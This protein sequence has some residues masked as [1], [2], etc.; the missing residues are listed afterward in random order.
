MTGGQAP[1][2]RP[3]KVGGIVRTGPDI[4]ERPDCGPLPT[5]PDTVRTRTDSAPGGVR[6][7]YTARIPRRQLGAAVVEALTLLA[8]E[9]SP[10]TVRT[11]P[12]TDAPDTSGRRSEIRA[13][14][15]DAFDLPPSILRK[16][17]TQ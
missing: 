2:S 4:G 15:A 12:D 1:D 16:D 9:I 14:I 8:A 6:F 17:P 5:R 11:A 7:A 10:D 13:S 3:D